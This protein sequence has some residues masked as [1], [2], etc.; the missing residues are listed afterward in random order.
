[1]HK[2]AGEL[3]DVTGGEPLVTIAMP[4]YN[5]GRYL[6]P[7][8]ISILQQTFADWELIVID[9]G[10]SD[11]AVEGIRDLP[12]ARIRVLRD[13]LNKGLAARLNEAIDLARGRFFA[14]MD[15]DDVS[16][17]ERLARQL[18]L[19]EW[20]PEID[21]CAV[22]CVAIDADDELVGIMPHAL[23]HEAICARPWIGFHLPHPTWLG[24]IEWFRRHRYASPGPYF[25]EDQELLL[26]SYGDSRFAATPEI[27][28]AYRVRNGINWAKSVKTRRTLFRLQLRRFLA[29][30]QYASCALAAGAAA[31]R[32]AMDSLNA[33]THKLGGRGYKRHDA[34]PIEPGVRQ[35]WRQIATELLLAGARFE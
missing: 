27:L 35:R 24:R 34:A 13:G 28:L 23:T 16:Y 1:L 8:V 25:C 10:S 6:R 5:A 14:R 18:A 20:N 31:A 15:Q 32:I 26:R 3:A 2:P 9:D 17:P 22:R 12:D 33:L 30:R 11:G 19:L 29:A 21:L 4:V 7:A